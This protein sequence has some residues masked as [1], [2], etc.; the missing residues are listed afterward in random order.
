MATHSV[1]LSRDALAKMLK[2][3][4]LVASPHSIP[5]TRAPR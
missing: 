3:W 1:E 4:T 2:S 5:S